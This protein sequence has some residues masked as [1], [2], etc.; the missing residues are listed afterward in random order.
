[1]AFT[2]S[3][4]T[5]TVAT[6][7]A[8][9][10]TTAAVAA[11]VTTSATA[12]VTTTATAAIAAAITTSATATAIATTAAAKATGARLSGTRFIDHECAA[13]QLLAMHALDS[14]LRHR[15]IA[16]FDE[17]EAFR[18]AGLTLHH[19]ASAFHFAKCTKSLRQI[20]VAC[21]V[22]QVAHIQSV[23]HQGLHKNTNKKRRSPSS[24]HKH[25]NPITDPAVDCKHPHPFI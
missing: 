21:R 1:L 22:G 12:A 11:A 2:G 14:G 16:H 5:T 9:I 18:T 23:A 24:K 15:V 13:A 17:P 10:T 7:A 4:L 25:D 20:F 19:H 3:L 8:A 6:A